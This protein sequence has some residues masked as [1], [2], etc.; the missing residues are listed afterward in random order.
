VS[1][2]LV[3]LRHEAVQVDLQ[4]KTG[5][6]GEGRPP[7][8]GA[9]ALSASPQ[10]R[11]VYL[12]STVEGTFTG[13]RAQL[14]GIELQLQAGELPPLVPK[15]DSGEQML[16]MPPLSVAFVVLPEAGVASCAV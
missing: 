8:D 16:T 2:A 6:R 12:L 4:F 1:V 5:V 11:E 13:H 9:A 7:F 3:N 14:N 10:R 15:V